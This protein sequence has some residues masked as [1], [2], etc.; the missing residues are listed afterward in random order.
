MAN[1]QKFLFL[2]EDGQLK[3]QTGLDT[4]QI[5][6]GVNSADAVNK[7]QLDAVEA[8]LESALST[9]QSAREAADVA[10]GGRIDTEISDRQAA[11]SSL[12]SDLSDEVSRAT[13]A[14]QAIA[15]DLATEISDRQTAITNLNSALSADILAEQTR[16]EAAE[17][18]LSSSLTQEISDRT[19]AVLAEKTRAEGVEADLLSAIN[20]EITDRTAAVSDEASARAAGDLAEKN[21]AEGVEADLQSQ[22]TQ[23]V[24]DREAAITSL[25]SSLSADLT[26]EI[27]RATAAEGV[28]QTNIDNEASARAT[29][30]T[31]EET[32][33]IAG[34]AALASDLSDEVARAMGAESDLSDAIA[35]EASDRAAAVLAEKNRAEGVEAQL[36]SDIAGEETARIQAVS[37]E[38][39]RAEA[40]EAQLTTD[41]GVETQARID[42]DA[43]TLAEA[44]TYADGLVSGVTF[45]NS[46]RVALPYEFEMGG[47]TI[48]LPA[49]FM[50]IKGPAGLDAGDR[51]LLINKDDGSTSAVEGIYV[52]NTAGTAL[53]R[54]PDMIVG[55]DASGVLTYVEEGVLGSGLPFATPGTSFVCANLKGGDIVGTDAL[56]FAVFSRAEALQFTKGTKKEG[57]D[58][59]LAFA[60]GAPFVQDSG[61]DLVIDS[62]Y[63]VKVGGELTMQGALVSGGGSSADHLHIHKHAACVKPCSVA[64]GSFVKPDMTG[65]TWNSP[66]VFGLVEMD[67]PNAGEKVIVV[68][69]LG[70]EGMAMGK[71]DAFSIGDVV[72]LGGTAGEFSDFAGVPSGKYAVPVGRKCGSSEIVVQIGGAPALKA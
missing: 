19:A 32:A 55:S 37:A 58:V 7:G 46:V 50:T 18:A 4:I 68:S 5:A 35:Q 41:L 25:S 71:L 13:A 45:K 30:I 10:L 1:V 56:D 70:G 60:E 54:A 67:G 39:T 57:L 29:A 59:S 42:G 63:F 21:R 26:A 62:T 22:I 48:S 23:E 72:Y 17:S 40:A 15:A 20:A 11:I 64:S 66:A 52:V 9:E 36:A 6:D 14:E 47:S 43:A 16:A 2:G 31:A 3:Q 33:R 8:A 61:L 28:L 51:I 44:K 53:V 12:S 24:A 49:D 65:A 27:N 38:Q 34:D 69:G